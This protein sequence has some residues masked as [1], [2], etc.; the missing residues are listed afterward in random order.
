MRCFG[1][2]NATGLIGQVLA[3]LDEYAGQEDCNSDEWWQVNSR[4]FEW[5]AV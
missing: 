2:K 3:N 1:N 5:S 4:H